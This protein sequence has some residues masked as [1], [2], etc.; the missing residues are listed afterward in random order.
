MESKTTAKSGGILLIIVLLFSLWAAPTAPV[1]AQTGEAPPEDTGQELPPEEHQALLEEM[2]QS[3]SGPQPAAAGDCEIGTWQSVSPVNTGRS[4]P[5]LAYADFNGRFYLLGGES[6]GGDRDI[7][8]EEYDPAS[9]VWTEKANLLTGVAN[10]GAAAIGQFIYIPGGYNG[11]GVSTMQRYDIVAD[12]LTTVA[13]MSEGIFGHAVVA[14]NNKVHVLGGDVAGAAGTTHRIYNVATNSWSD[15]QPLPVPVNY[16]TAVTD[17]EQIYVLGGTTS[18][19]ATVQ[20]YNPATNSWDQLPDLGMGRGGAGSFFDGANVWAVAGGW[21]SYLTSTEYWD[22]ISWQNGPSLSLGAR[23]LGVAFGD[24]MALKV[25]GW[26]GDYEDDAEILQVSCPEPPPPA[27]T[28]GEWQAV[29]PLNTP[30]SRPGLAYAET[31]GHFYI[32]GG[33]STGSNRDIPIEE[34]DPDTGDW[35]DKSLLMTGVSNTD[36]VAIG[37]YLYV[38]GGYNGSAVA[39]LQRYDIGSDTVTTM[40]PMPAENFAHAVVAHEDKIHVLGGS[41]DGSASFTHY[42]Y[43]IA[44]NTW[45]NGAPLLTATRYAGAASDGQY[46]YVLGGDTTDLYTVQRYDSESNIWTEAPIMDQGRGG[47]G[48]FYDGFNLWAVGGGWS[49]YLTHTEYYDGHTWRTGPALNAGGRTLGVAFGDGLAL[50]AG[51]WN[52]NYMD[53]AETMSIVC[54]Q[55]VYLPLL[56]KPATLAAAPGN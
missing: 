19:L 5:G 4:R 25:A 15:G 26:N 35:T 13:P 34:F 49:T 48:A 3:S 16:A 29:N 38:P 40:A 20:R 10:T 37:S 45:D 51:G 56:L 22:G 21:G 28:F 7:P 36:A 23:T 33:E 46:I 8:I 12:S 39:D 30:R 47:G 11:A 24:G 18:D 44:S 54:Q 53:S 42:I 32:V 14:L 9:D 41:S 6:T 27:C 1:A 2:V 50:K 43:D 52:G 31:N 17:G 55:E